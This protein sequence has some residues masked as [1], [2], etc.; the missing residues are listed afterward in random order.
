MLTF[1]NYQFAVSLSMRKMTGIAISNTDT[2]KRVWVNSLKTCMKDHSL[3]DFLRWWWLCPNNHSSS[4]YHIVK[5]YFFCKLAMYNMRCNTKGY[6]KWYKNTKTA[7][8]SNSGFAII[9]TFKLM[10]MFNL[11]QFPKDSLSGEAQYLEILTMSKEEFTVWPRS[12]LHGSQ[13][14]WTRM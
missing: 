11:A 3:G 14:T 4:L 13:Q 1:C 8:I 5:W 9:I 10:I 12:P 6:F 2:G 7:C